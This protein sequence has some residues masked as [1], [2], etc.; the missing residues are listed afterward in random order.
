MERETYTTD[1]E[2]V[3]AKM[4][5]LYNLRLQIAKDIKETYTKDEILELLD[6]VAEEKKGGFW[7]EWRNIDF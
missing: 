6:A 7:N 3:D 4:A 5:M 2:R 1:V